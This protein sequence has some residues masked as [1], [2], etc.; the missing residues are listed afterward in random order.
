LPHLLHKF[1]PWSI[2]LIALAALTYR[3]GRPS[4][5]RAVRAMNPEVLWLVA[6]ALGGIVVMSLIPSKRVDRIY[7][8]I[9]PLCLLVGV[10]L[11][12]LN[13]RWTGW[14]AVSV[15]VAVLY[16]SG[17]AAARIVSGYRGNRGSLSDFG[18]EVRALAHEKNWRL[19]V[20]GKTDEGVPL[21]FDRPH[22]TNPD[23]AIS[24]WNLGTIDA[25]A[26]PADRLPRFMAELHN[27]VAPL[28]TSRPRSELPD[29]PNYVLLTH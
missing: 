5:L 28:L 2:I 21:Y 23:A 26:V 9:P 18:R 29:R 19:E 11:A 25:L 27:A 10:Q 22:F 16:T 1:A 12:R 8:A 20:V 14:I 17:Y 4:V 13:A 15:I 24:A 6:W 3:A 7:P